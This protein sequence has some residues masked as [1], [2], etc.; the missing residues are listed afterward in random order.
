MNPNTLRFSDRVEDYIKHRPHYPKELIKLLKREAG[1]TR[2]SVVADIGSGTGISSMQFLNNGNK[3]YAV[4]PNKEMRQA[5]ERLLASQSNFISIDGSAE[6][7]TLP[8]KSVDMIFSG[9]AFHWFDKKKAKEEF[10][11]IL[12]D[13]GKIAFVWNERDD[14]SPFLREYEQILKE[15]I[16]EYSEV[17]HRNSSVA[18]IKEFFNPKAMLSFSLRNHQDLDLKGLKGRLLSASYCPKKGTEHDM[19]MREIEKLFYKYVKGGSVRFE[20]ETVVYIR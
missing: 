14:C 7:T 19:L 20:Y 13:D 15:C 2:N 4:E 17:N 1:L 12:K 6:E 18:G 3:V 16:K 9:Q 5:A 10:L 8:E 11:R